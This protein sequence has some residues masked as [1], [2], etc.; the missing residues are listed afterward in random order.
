MKTAFFNDDLAE[1]VY[2]DSLNFSKKLGSHYL[3]C[4]LK[5]PLYY[6]IIYIE[7]LEYMTW[8]HLIL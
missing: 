5:E 2:I 7:L 1:I 8:I 3:M 4:K 6:F